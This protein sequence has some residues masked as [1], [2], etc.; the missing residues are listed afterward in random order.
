MVIAASAYAEEGARQQW[1]ERQ[2]CKPAA[3]RAPHQVVNA[4][5][6]FTPRGAGVVPPISGGAAAGSH[7]GPGLFD[8][9]PAAKIRKRGGGG[10]G[11]GGGA[12]QVVQ[13]QPVAPTPPAP[14]K[15][16]KW[17]VLRL[18]PG[19]V[20]FRGDSLPQGL[21]TCLRYLQ[22]AAHRDLEGRLPSTD[23]WQ[24]PAGHRQGRRQ[25]RSPAEMTRVCTTFA[26]VGATGG[27]V[28]FSAAPLIFFKFVAVA[29]AS[30]RAR[31]AS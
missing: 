31:A 30:R 24:G 5:E 18:Q 26:G 7:P 28:D 4:L 21:P 14:G 12:A 9:G 20:R 27:A 19:Q 25:G 8:D 13:D 29:C 2:V 3:S 10:R 17:G 6:G 22:R 23:Q 16:K 1:W 11:N 15:G